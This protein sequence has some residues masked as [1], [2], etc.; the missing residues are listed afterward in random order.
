MATVIGIF[1][2]GLYVELSLQ[3]LQREGLTRE[4]IHCFFLDPP[5]SIR[6]QHSPKPDGRTNQVDLGFIFATIFGVTGASIGFR[7]ILG[8]IFWGIVSSLIGFLFGLL[9]NFCYTRTFK[10]QTT[11]FVI[12]AVNCPSR[13]QQT[14]EQVFT[15]NHA[16]GLKVDS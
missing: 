2:S 10:E 5:K 1:R 13:L 6:I 4:S 14:I 15:V 8:P 7:I 12:I 11:A 9:I 16:L 3:A